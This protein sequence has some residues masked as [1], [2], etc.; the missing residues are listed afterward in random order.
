M[1]GCSLLLTFRDHVAG[2]L[3]D[4]RLAALLEDWLPPFRSPF[5]YYFSR[6]Q[7]APPVRAFVDFVRR[8]PDR[9]PAAP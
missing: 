6:R 4:G 5:L 8:Q 3:Q 9:T 2:P 1:A 7:M